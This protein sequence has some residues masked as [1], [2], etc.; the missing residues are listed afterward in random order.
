MRAREGRRSI[1]QS[2]ANIAAT[3]LELTSDDLGQLNAVSAPTPSRPQWIQDM[4]AHM[5]VPA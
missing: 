2:T 5:R 4:L 1:T 3:D